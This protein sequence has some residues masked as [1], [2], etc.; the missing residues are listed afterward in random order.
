V[1]AHGAPLVLSYSPTTAYEGSQPRVMTLEA[2]KDLA[3]CYFST[4]E[5]KSPSPIS[6]SKLNSAERILGKSVDAERLM[7]CRP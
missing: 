5:V 1:R 2:L 7:I 4:V 3:K 6:H